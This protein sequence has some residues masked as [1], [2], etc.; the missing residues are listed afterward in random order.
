MVFPKAGE[1]KV[2]IYLRK[3]KIIQSTE[4]NDARKHTKNQNNQSGVR[5]HFIMFF[6]QYYLGGRI[7]YYGVTFSGQVQIDLL[8]MSVRRP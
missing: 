7:G 1:S 4:K 3:L 5:C 8:S 6:I 2:L